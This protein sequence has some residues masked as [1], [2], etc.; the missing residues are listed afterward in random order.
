M[1]ILFFTPDF[2]FPLVAGACKASE[3]AQKRSRNY[4]A[5]LLQPGAGEAVNTIG[6]PA[7][8][9]QALQRALYQPLF[10]KLYHPF[11]M[12]I[13]R[14]ARAFEHQTC[15]KLGSKPSLKVRSFSLKVRPNN[16]PTFKD[17]NL[18]R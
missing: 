6:A 8:T 3:K 15:V 7:I 17:P 2:C 12:K 9:S 5:F 14:S 13:Q 16:R 11:L 4:R 1:P 18:K 10:K